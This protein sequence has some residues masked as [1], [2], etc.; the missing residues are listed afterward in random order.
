ML[1]VMEF[2]VV[3]WFWDTNVKLI[4]EL[5]ERVNIVSV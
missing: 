1:S 4:L 5:N 3:M 2:V